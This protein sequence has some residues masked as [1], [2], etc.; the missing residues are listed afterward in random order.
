M[1]MVHLQLLMQQ[2]GP[3]LQ[4]MMSNLLPLLL[5]VLL[6]LLLWSIFQAG[7]VAEVQ[8]GV[9][10]QLILEHSLV[11]NLDLDKP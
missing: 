3:L 4:M 9:E 7:T 1:Y 6:L 10:Q 11:E 5:P 8:V 2:P